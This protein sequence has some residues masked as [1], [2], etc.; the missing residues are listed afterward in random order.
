MVLTDAISLS[1]QGFA[2]ILD[3]TDKV[4]RIVEDSGIQKR[5]K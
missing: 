2:D 3:I 4:A 1:T 5:L